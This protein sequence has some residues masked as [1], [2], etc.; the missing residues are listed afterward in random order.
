MNALPTLFVSHGA[1][2]ILLSD[3]PA[4][5]FLEELGASIARPDAIAVVSAHYTRPTPGVTAAPEP[6]TIHDFRGFPAPL[7]RLHY[8][9]PGAPDLAAEVAAALVDAGRPAREDHR[10]GLDHGA[11]VPLRL[12]Y[13]AA[14]IPVVE[15]SVAPEAGADEHAAI[16]RALAFLPKRNVLVVASGAMSHNLT[17][18]D[19]HDPPPDWVTGFT[20][21]MAETLAA[22]DQEAL[23]EYRARAPDAARNHPTEEH[24]LPLFVAMGAA[25]DTARWSARRLHHSVTHGVIAMDSYA[26]TASDR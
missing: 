26:F 18:L 12:M 23:L 24:L 7:Y 15:I 22:G 8:P 13:P 4:R 21:W 20:T 9:A 17:E 11:W 16:G 5:R 25:D 19:R 6:A 14:D 3:A 1:P 10:R 2:D